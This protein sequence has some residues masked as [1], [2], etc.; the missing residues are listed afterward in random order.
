MRVLAFIRQRSFARYV[1]VDLADA[2]RRMGWDVAWVDLDAERQHVAGLPVEA[3]GAAVE[4]VRTRL[5]AVAPDLVFSYGLE[6][7]AAVFGD[8]VPDARWTVADEAR[9][10]VACF[11]F[12]F[13]YPFNGTAD[14]PALALRERLRAPDVALWCWDTAAIADLVALGIPAQPFPMAV[15][16][17]MFFPPADAAAVRDLPVVFSGGPTPARIA[18]LERLAPLGLS[19]YGY[20]PD[21]WHRSPALRASHRGMVAERGA[22]RGVYQRAQL[23]VNVT[24]A[25]GRASLNMRVFEAMACGCVM[26]T[27]QA[28]AARALFDV[29]TELA[30]YTTAD[31]LEARARHLLR[32]DQARTRLAAAGAVAVR[33][34]HTYRHRL[35][36]IAGDL[37]ALLVEGRAWQRFL[38]YL[39]VDPAKAG[40]FVEALRAEGVLRRL[41]IWPL[42]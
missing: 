28:E 17:Q 35:S 21:A 25:H 10:P 30:T 12:D 37:K 3:R 38:G 8:L 5:A 14:A 16:E 4:A 31:D 24:R 11:L 32:D 34:R 40:R 13:G 33:T 41:D 15:N 29:D 23:A 9:A 26:L 18:A 36:A 39:A 22:L 6:A 27:D 1:A 19:V 7:F 42:R 20:D 2:A